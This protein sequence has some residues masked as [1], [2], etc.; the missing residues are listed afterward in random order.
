MNDLMKILF[1]FVSEAEKSKKPFIDDNEIIEDVKTV[2]GNIRIK[3]PI[4]FLL[5]CCAAKIDNSNYDIRKPYT[6]ISGKGT[7]SGRSYDEKF[8]QKIIEHFDLPCNPTTA[9]LTPA[10]RNR[11]TIMTPETVLLGRNPDLYRTALKL[12]DLVSKETITPEQLF[13]EIIRQLVI[14]R[15]QSSDRIE[16]LLKGL[17]G[18]DKESY[19]SSE[20]IVTLLTQHLASKNSSRLPVLIVAAAYLTVGEK[21]G[22]RIKSLHTHNTADKQTGA[23]GDI[24]VVLSNEENIVTCY[25]MK[26]KRVY[27]VNSRPKPATFE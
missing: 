13:K 19:L 8:I 26:E 22:E 3:A 12:L 6:E 5:S 4:R 23:L 14:I 27:H 21:I 24:E 15:N 2:C 10:F 11:N 20:Q 18:N 7:F 25:E 9:F 16:Q 17:K 1:T